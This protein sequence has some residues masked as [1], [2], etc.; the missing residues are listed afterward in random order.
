MGNTGQRTDTE[1][2]E[3]L[4]VSL[5]DGISHTL[6]QLSR[7]SE[8]AVDERR[9]VQ[10]QHWQTVRDISQASLQLLEG[11]S[12]TLRLQ[13]GADEPVVAPL[14]TA[15]LLHDTALLLEPYAKQFGVQI[16]LDVATRIEPILSDKLILQSA[17][18]SLGQVFIRAHAET[19]NPKP[20][21]LAAHKTRYG[22]VIGLYGHGL[23]MTNATLRRARGLQGKAVQP[24]SQF[25]SGP[26]SGV[27]VADGLLRTVASQLH[28]ARYHNVSGLAATLPGCQQL[29]F[30]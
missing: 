5:V 25:V 3:R 28:A 4:F 15:T 12:M 26:A 8:V 18:L 14:A 10:K 19:E 6:L 20:I 17:L 24:Y 30:V 13:S 2:Q 11:Y 1:S 22:I 7:L 9:P 29:Q 23:D 16:E 21:R 27:F